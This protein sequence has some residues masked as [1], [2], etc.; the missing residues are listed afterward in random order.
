MA[1]NEGEKI[2]P[3][4]EEILKRVADLMAEKTLSTRDIA[5]LV[6]KEKGIGYRQIYKE[7]IARKRTVEKVATD[8]TC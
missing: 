6:S 4:S 2:Q 7:C 5:A 1:G 8:G 3:L